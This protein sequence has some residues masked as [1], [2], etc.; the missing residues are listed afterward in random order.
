MPETFVD[1]L[2]YERAP[3]RGSL[4]R[5]LRAY[6]T[7][8]PKPEPGALVAVQW[9]KEQAH[10]G[11]YTGPTL[12]HAFEWR[13]TVIEHGFAGRWRRLVV[14]SYALPGVRYG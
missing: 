7:P 11:I 10:V 2:H 6:C 9:K 1:T 5:E 12:I 4:E 14:A 8:L 13:D 3:S